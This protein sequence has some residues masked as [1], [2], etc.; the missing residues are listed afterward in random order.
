MITEDL[1]K[2]TA[3]KCKS[4]KEWADN[5]NKVLP[6]YQ[7]DTKLR[8][9]HFL[10]QCLNE[11]GGF[12]VLV[13]NLNYSKDGLLK[14]FPKYFSEKDAEL[15]QRK[16]QAIANRVYGNRMG[17]GNEASGDGFKY[18]GRGIIQLTGKDNYTKFSKDEYMSDIAV[19]NPDIVCEVDG[20]IRSA[21][22]YWK[23]NNVNAIADKG[24]N[25]LAVTKCVN[26]GS[27]GLVERQRYFD[28]LNSLL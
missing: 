1:L 19:T 28:L 21:C 6:R 4:P 11:T 26:G 9:T 27:I 16:P 12:T 3:P 10:A 23:R 22:W 15:Y 5:L 18:R 2:K 13:E 8:V 14:I 7:I 24:P 25:I 20:A 17:N